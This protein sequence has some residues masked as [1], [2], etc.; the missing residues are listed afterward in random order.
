MRDKE[1]NE[2][3]LDRKIQRQ[4]RWDKKKGYKSR[5]NKEKE[6]NDYYSRK[7]DN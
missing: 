7:E 6:R 5:E 2:T 4:L 1:T 3:T